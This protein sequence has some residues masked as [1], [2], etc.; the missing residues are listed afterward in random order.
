MFPL[1]GSP[2]PYQHHPYDKC[3]PAE[4]NSTPHTKGVMPS[5]T[6]GICCQTAKSL[7]PLC[8][9]NHINTLFPHHF[10]SSHH[11]F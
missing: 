10:H 3:A 1:Y 4:E 5:Y 7:R 8:K 6:K 2:H 11:C 9:K